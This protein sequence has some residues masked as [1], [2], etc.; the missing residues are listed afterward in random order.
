MGIAS[1]VQPAHDL[2][3]PLEIAAAVV[4]VATT[5]G[6]AKICVPDLLIA[7]IA[8]EIHVIA[9]NVGDQNQVGFRQS[10]EIRG[11][12]RI[13]V[14]VLATRF[15]QHRGVIKRRNF[16]RARGRIKGLRRSIRLG[17]RRHHRQKHKNCEHGHD[18]SNIHRRFLCVGVAA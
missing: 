15:D 12:C 2:V 13:D 4:T 16:H 11:L 17:C 6:G 7:A 14:N 3:S 18:S 1:I 9:V 5:A 10:A 8:S